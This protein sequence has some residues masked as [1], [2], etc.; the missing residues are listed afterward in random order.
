MRA[1]T[2]IAWL[3]IVLM[4]M[5]AL[6]FTPSHWPFWAFMWLF[7]WTIFA[8]C[9]WLTWWT[10]SIMNRQREQRYGKIHRHLG[11]LMAWPGLDAA[12]FLFGPNPRVPL[13]SS[14]LFCLGK[15]SFGIVL[16]ACVYPRLPPEREVLR[17]WIGMVGIIFVLHFGLF[18]LLSLAWQALGVSARPI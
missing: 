9:K 1:V 8:G 15:F 7:A 13:P 2:I 16:I 6:L 3:P 12:T 5:A 17:G 10:A 4:P 14:W 11:Y 18:Q